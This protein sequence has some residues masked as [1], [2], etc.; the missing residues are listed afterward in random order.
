M[1]F[2][3]RFKL[4]TRNIQEV[5]T[6]SELTSAMKKN[7]HLTVYCG[8]E[9]SGPVHIGN[10]ISVQK[11]ID[12]KKAG[13]HV[14]VLLAD[15]HTYLNKK[16]DVERIESMCEYWQACFKKLGLHASFIKGS[17]FQLS[18][19]YIDDIYRL[20]L[21]LP[22]TRAKRSMDM[23]GRDMD[24]PMLSQMLY[25]L[26]QAID[27]K[28]LGVA[29]AF[30]GMDQ[31]RIHML[32]REILPI[33]KYKKPIIIHNP[34]LP[35]ILGPRSKMSSSKPETMI[36]VH[37]S[38]KAIKTKVNRSYCVAGSIENNFP[39]MVLKNFI[40]PR[41]GAVYM[42]RH[43]KY[44]GDKVYETY[45]ELERAFS[46]KEIHPEDLKNSVADALVKELEPCRKLLKEKKVIKSLFSE[47]PKTPKNN[48][49]L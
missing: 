8:Y 43:E 48:G 3:K 23:V 16:G 36:T 4:V 7:K 5:V 38:E 21:S 12:F 18:R 6:A 33:R 30:G 37:D 15:V 20:S 42:K 24:S 2:K 46:K 9:P 27:V 28:H 45:D 10:A 41:T 13:W 22:L 26:M 34:I 25:P 29:V 35:S 31:R 14:K 32:A 1:D 47:S 11:L 39:L 49:K 44:G 17:S 40:I 19:K